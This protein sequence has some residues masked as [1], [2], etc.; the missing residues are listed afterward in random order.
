MAGIMSTQTSEKDALARA[1]EAAGGYSAVAR[2]LGISFQAVYKWTR[3][4]VERCADLERLSGRTV[5]R[6]DL[7]PDIFGPV[8]T[9]T[10]RAA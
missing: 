2:E 9:A 1:I 10:E 4:P 3:A 7:R 6:Q 5:R 8:R